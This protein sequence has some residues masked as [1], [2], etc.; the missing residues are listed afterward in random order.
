MFVTCLLSLLHEGR[1]FVPRAWNRDWHGIAE[2]KVNKRAP[3]T[4]TEAAQVDVGP[5]SDLV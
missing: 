4:T 1:N 5:L 2:Q 3:S